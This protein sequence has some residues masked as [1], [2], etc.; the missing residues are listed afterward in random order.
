MLSRTAI[1]AALADIVAV[2]VFAAVGR[3]SH[4]ESGDVVGLLATAAPFLVGVA[5]SWLLRPVR[6][7]PAT[8]SAGLTVWIGTLV[9]GLAIRTVF[10]RSL[11][12]TFL[13]VAAVTLAALLIGWRGLAQLVARRAR[14]DARAG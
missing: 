4:A 6:R 7:A 5:A 8:L 12:L 11:P 1:L 10:T 2:L 3:L 9:V 13:L 14:S